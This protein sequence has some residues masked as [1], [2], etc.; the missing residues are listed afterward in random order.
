MDE[1]I[2]DLRFLI[3]MRGLHPDP[4]GARREAWGAEGAESGRSNTIKHNETR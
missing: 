2:F 4:S 1:D 3:G